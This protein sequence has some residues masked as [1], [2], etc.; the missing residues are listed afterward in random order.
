M[1]ECN[2]HLC[3]KHFIVQEM[4]SGVAC[5]VDATNGLICFEDSNE[6]YCSICPMDARIEAWEEHI[7]DPTHVQTLEQFQLIFGQ[8]DTRSRCKLCD[9]NFDWR[10]L[11]HHAK[12]HIILPWHRPYN[13]DEK[14]KILFDNRIIEWQSLFHCCICNTTFA[15]FDVAFV[16]IADPTHQNWKEETA[17][18]GYEFPDNAIT[19]DFLVFECLIASTET[20]LECR[21]C[22][23][24]KVSIENISRHVKGLMHKS[25]RSKFRL[26]FKEREAKELVQQINDNLQSKELLAEDSVS[27]ESMSE[28]STS[29][30]STPNKIGTGTSTDNQKIFRQS[31][32]CNYIV[33]RNSTDSYCTLCN[34][35][36]FHHSAD[37]HIRNKDHVDALKAY[38]CDEISFNNGSDYYC[39]ICNRTMS[40]PAN[41]YDHVVGNKHVKSLKKSRQEGL[42]KRPNEVR[43]MQLPGEDIE[44]RLLKGPN[45]VRAMQRPKEDIE[46][47]S[48][49]DG[50]YDADSRDKGH[51]NCIAPLADNAF[52]CTCC[53]V[54]VPGPENLYLHLK[55]K[56]HLRLRS[57]SEEQRVR[58]RP[59]NFGFL[60]RPN[61]S[62]SEDGLPR[63]PDTFAKQKIETGSHEA[64]KKLDRNLFGTEGRCL[65]F[66]S[67][68][69][70]LQMK[71]E[72]SL[73]T[74][75]ITNVNSQTEEEHHSPSNN[76]LGLRQ[77]RMS[78]GSV[79]TPTSPEVFFQANDESY[80][81]SS[82]VSDQRRGRTMRSLPIP[83]KP[84]HNPEKLIESLKIRNVNSQTKEQYYSTW[85]KTLDLPQVPIHRGNFET[86][87]RPEVVFHAE[88]E[89][90]SDSS[91]ESGK[92]RVQRA[93]SLAIPR[94]PKH[95]SEKIF[96]SLQVSNVNPQRKEEYCSALETTSGSQQVETSRNNLH[97][98]T[99]PEV[100]VYV[101]NERPP[102]SSNE[103]AKRQAP[104]ADL[105]VIPRRPKHVPEHML[106]S[107]TC[108]Y[109][110]RFNDANFRCEVCDCILTGSSTNI[111]IHITG[112]YHTASLKRYGCQYITPKGDAVYH[113]E[114]CDVDIARVENVRLHIKSHSHITFVIG[115]DRHQLQLLTGEKIFEEMEKPD[116][117]PDQSDH[118]SA[119]PTS[120]STYIMKMNDNVS[121]CE[122]CDVLLVD[123][124]ET[125]DHVAGA[126]HAAAMDKL[127]CECVVLI[128]GD[129]H[130]CKSCKCNISGRE[131]VCKHVKGRRH[132]FGLRQLSDREQLQAAKRN[133][134]RLKTSEEPDSNT[135]LSMVAT[136]MSKMVKKLRILERK[137][138]RNQTTMARLV[139]P[140][141]AI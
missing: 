108:H 76:P 48:E 37:N 102:D 100:A 11:K 28:N 43:A 103:P 44:G 122:L 27:E 13:E 19:Y 49:L 66:P 126:N 118:E 63:L 120:P 61:V 52:Y 51:S 134:N 69:G 46:E 8:I 130:Y 85:D 77:Y 7:L 141:A 42:L 59:H 137:N 25:N 125:S 72:K 124:S 98:P 140:A 3:D 128:G 54:S 123:S 56:K 131:N 127:G 81:D 38:G 83:R 57:L 16:H 67:A 138:R 74:S 17:V 116:G 2:F 47:V 90:R 91:D 50:N 36:F 70:K 115:I 78:R 93:S 68:S 121:H 64:P 109:L 34:C 29:E 86:A 30:E 129:D 32:D 96:E 58:I 10:V 40:G 82:T 35:V 12:L 87:R 94:R 136:E 33:K 119:R 6:I 139:V 84:K 132:F 114:C 53:N 79:E 60:R 104:R 21:I 71:K 41:V 111:N 9:E 24:M 5:K 55:G 89:R 92:R 106:A 1:E 26:E 101:R 88:D 80:S 62:L 31:V 97:T 39:R 113:C 133:L 4:S 117:I 18:F 23:S 14:Y 73:V 110:V 112:N 20:A 107:A 15:T 22:H 99:R 105:S 65:G 45:E 95:I 135:D 75:E